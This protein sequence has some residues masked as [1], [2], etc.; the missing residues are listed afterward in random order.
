MAKII[1]A[2]EVAKAMNDEWNAWVDARK[3]FLGEHHVW[4][5]FFLDEPADTCS[6]CSDLKKNYPSNNLTEDELIAKHF[7]QVRKVQN[8]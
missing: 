4:C 6:M 1:P 8:G 2:K 7:P 3:A 5:N